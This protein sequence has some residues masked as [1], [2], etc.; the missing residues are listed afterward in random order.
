MSWLSRSTCGN[1][2]SIPHE[3]RLPKGFVRPRVVKHPRHSRRGSR[4]RKLH[5]P[6][7][8]Y[9]LLCVYQSFSICSVPGVEP[10]E[11]AIRTEGLFASPQAKLQSG[12]L[13]LGSL[14]FPSL[15]PC[16]PQCLFPCH[17]QP[18]A[19]PIV[20]EVILQVTTRARL[21]PIP[22]KLLASPWPPST[23][24]EMWWV[25]DR[26]LGLMP[27]SPSTTPNRDNMTTVKRR[28]HLPTTYA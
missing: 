13:A 15:R 12:Q 27:H 5:L 1:D 10:C 22:A 3:R 9:S 8:F 16:S 20:A 24:M 26:L 18:E 21:A 25:N 14:E 11:R 23:G 7:W 19:L 2:L 6:G 28:A 4:R 17:R